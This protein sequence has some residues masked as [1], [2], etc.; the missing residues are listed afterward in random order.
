MTTGTDSA[1]CVDSVRTSR[2]SF[3][4]W[5]RHHRKAHTV[6]GDLAR[7]ALADRGWPR[8]PGSHDRYLNYLI[9]CGACQGALAA[10]EAAWQLYREETP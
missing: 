10:F 1:D 5:L 3:R 8:G 4:A 6:I 7:D 9:D 2:T